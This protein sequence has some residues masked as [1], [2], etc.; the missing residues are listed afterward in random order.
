M[1]FEIK[2]WNVHGAPF[3]VAALSHWKKTLGDTKN[4]EYIFSILCNRFCCR[5]RC[6]R[7]AS[8]SY[9]FVSLDKN[10]IEFITD[11]W[12]QD[13]PKMKCSTKP[14]VGTQTYY[15]SDTSANRGKIATKTK[16]VV[17][18]SGH[19][20]A[21]HCLNSFVSHGILAVLQMTKDHNKVADWLQYAIEMRCSLA[22]SF[23]ALSWCVLCTFILCFFI[24]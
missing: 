22:G 14:I 1:K 24:W 4:N 7:R 6:H 5:C 2:Y 21:I 10:L 13:P 12:M 23:K 11:S 19:W 20:N 16:S 8:N 15:K 3:A 17:P 9:I 18:F